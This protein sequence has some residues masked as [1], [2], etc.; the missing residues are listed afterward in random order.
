MVTIYKQP[1]RFQQKINTRRK[2]NLP[3]TLANIQ[4]FNSHWRLMATALDETGRGCS[5]VTENDSKLCCFNINEPHPSAHY[6]AKA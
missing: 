3:V 1:L 6:K 4:E 5:K 2:L